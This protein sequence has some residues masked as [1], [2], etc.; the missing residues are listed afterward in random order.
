MHDVI[1][2][3]AGM[4]GVSTALA[5]QERGLSVAL[6]D[7]GDPLAQ[8]S[9]G[10]A[11]IIQAEAAEPYAMPRA[12]GELIAIAL[13]RSNAV[14]WQAAALPGLWRPLWSYFRN[15]ASA[16]HRRIARTY[17]QLTARATADHA[18]WIAAA[19]A[20]GL[21][22][23]EGFLLA[24]RNP[25]ALAQAVA[26]AE[27]LSRDYG[28][29]FAALDSAALGRA[30]P[31]LRSTPAGAIHWRDAWSC[32]DP[33]ALVAAYAAL[34]RA[35]GGRTFRGDAMSLSRRADAWQVETRDEGVQSARQAVIALGAGSAA[36]C[37]RF[38][39]SVP[40]IPKRGYH[41]HLDVTNG[42]RRPIV[43]A[44]SSTV[45]AP[46][47][48]GLRILT[49]AEIGHGPRPR[50][51]QMD[52]ARQAAAELFE[53]G[54]PVDPA[55]WSGLR[56]CMPDMLPVVGPLRRH[57]GLWA[58]F[59]HGHQGFTLGPTTAQLLAEAM[60]GAHP[61]PETLTPARLPGG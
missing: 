48:R 11:G 39:L 51:V 15:S 60:T 57:P 36:L 53:T 10:N 23:R 5:L 32:S 8:S 28:V 13:R 21:I 14:A 27:R 3:G 16:R 29:R 4:A 43:D 1:V 25:A 7:W 19:G 33:G 6:I 17:A 24:L 38:G 56:P 22:A 34:F 35:R 50:P 46:M 12:P 40:L 55:P 47:R 18:P 41:L 42:P 30:E 49:G 44:A 9:Y 52:R 54:A 58:H 20:E 61:L 37:R 31:G 26:E 2:L 59:G 45:L